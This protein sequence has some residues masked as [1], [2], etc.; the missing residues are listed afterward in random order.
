MID[1]RCGLH[2]TDCSFLASHGCGGC[3][4]TSGH[5]FHG[6]CPVAG[7]CQAKGHT[8]CGQCAIIPCRKLYDYSY[9]DPQHGDNPP[10]ARVAVCRDWAAREGKHFWENV[11]LTSAGFEDNEKKQKI[12]I[13]KRF[14]AMLNKP[15]QLCK[16]LFIPTAARDREALYFAQWCHEELVRIGFQEN[17]ITVYNLDSTLNLDDVLMY[18]VMYFTGGDT[19][20]LLSRI[21]E[22]GFESI[23]KPFVYSGKV[24][25]GVSAGSLIAA[26]FVQNGTGTALEGLSLIHAHLTV[27]EAEGTQP[28]GNTPLPHIP[29]SDNQ[30]VAVSWKGYELIES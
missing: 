23:I 30:A 17:N 26:P 27:H 24:Y 11:L 21:K 7:C 13:I 3:I 9:C 20:H 10:G 25:V 6:A 19:V 12:K 18:D 28:L 2:C 1:S 29:L 5:P 4:E 22:K 16:V 15:P 8:H 14:L